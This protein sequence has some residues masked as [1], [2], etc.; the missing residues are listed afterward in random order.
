MN[1]MIMDMLPKARLR[2]LIVVIMCRN[3]H[4]HPFLSIMMTMLNEKI[5]TFADS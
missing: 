1:E 4:H 5:L 3:K 2:T